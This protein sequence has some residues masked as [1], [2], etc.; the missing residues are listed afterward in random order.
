MLH[1]SVLA[2]LC[3]VCFII[4][5]C[6]FAHPRNSLS[7]FEGSPIARDRCAR[8]CECDPN[9]FFH[10]YGSLLSACAELDVSAEEAYKELWA[11]TPSPPLLLLAVFITHHY[12]NTRRESVCV[13]VC[14]HMCVYFKPHLTSGPS[15]PLGVRQ[16]CHRACMLFL[17]RLWLSEG[18]SCRA[19]GVPHALCVH[20]TGGDLF[21]SVF[22]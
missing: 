22:R 9:S 6:L 12:R 13:C 3:I 21:C 1:L 8:V 11:L 15:S 17:Y 19:D 7:L 4:S 16:A 18:H 20:L 10:R 14:G 5:I 2:H